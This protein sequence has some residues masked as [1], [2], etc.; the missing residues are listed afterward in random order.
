MVWTGLLLKQCLL[1]FWALWFSVAWLANVC[2]GLHAC[3]RLG[4]GWKF[5]S[6]NYALLVETT[7]KYHPPPW[8]TAVLFV[9]VLCWEGGAALLFW[10]AF[11]AF[12]GVHQPGAQTLYP[13]FLVSLALW[14]AFLLADELCL[15][16]ETEATHLRVFVAQLVSLLVLTVLPEGG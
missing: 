1:L 14:A 5:V 4:A 6:G 16:Y 9:G 12:H 3:H 8:L 7:R 2:D 10:C 15:A 11:G 13:A